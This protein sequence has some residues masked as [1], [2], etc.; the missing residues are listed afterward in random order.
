MAGLTWNPDFLVFRRKEGQV[1][2]RN[3]I[4]GAMVALSLSEYDLLQAYSQNNS[5]EHVRRC[6]PD[7]L[8]EEDCFLAVV[9][10][11]KE[12]H[13]LQ[14]AGL[15]DSK[16]RRDKG[17]LSLQL[18]YLGMRLCRLLSFLSGLKIQAE[19][20]GNLRFF[21]ILS[22]DLNGTW[23]H[24]LA[25]R[26]MVQKLFWPFLAVLYISLLLTIFLHPSAHFS[27]AGFAMDE[28]PGMGLFALLVFGIFCCLS[29][30]ETG[31]YFVYKR[32][33]GEGDQIGI[34]TMFTVF[35]VMYT[36]ID[37]TCLWQSKRQ[38][39][40]LSLAGVLMDLLIMLG[41][42]CL[43]CFYHECNLFSLCLDCLLFYYLVQIATNLNPLFP[44]TDGY[45]L[46]EDILGLQRW[47][48]Y[49]FECVKTLWTSLRKG[50]WPKLQ[51]KEGLGAAYFLLAAICITLYWLMITALLTYPLWSS[52]L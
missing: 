41:L 32:Y 24:K 44:G 10:R 7:V 33:R 39:I 17:L 35:P 37:D 5:L 14:E 8:L 12:L 6:L 16:G 28:V 29:I 46:M 52:S 19:C 43:L 30:H 9:A 20:R 22:I 40:L 18:Y 27:L 47:Y 26:P 15:T 3:D 23:L 51:L 36:Q 34:G 21:K 48:G 50:C 25:T 1:V 31:H 4:D 11:A 42:V 2:V 49:S 45:Y 13:L 38:K